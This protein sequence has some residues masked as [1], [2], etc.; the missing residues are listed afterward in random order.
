VAATA[1]TWFS[2]RR[3][4]WFIYA[5]VLAVGL[6]IA[7]SGQPFWQQVALSVGIVALVALSWDILARCG[8]VSLGQS[9]FMGIGAYAAGILAPRIGAPAGMILAVLISAAAAAGLGAITLRLRGMYFSIATMGFTLSLQVA[10][11]IFPDLTGGAGGISPPTLAGG[12][13]AGQM[14]WVT[15]ALL[16]AAVVS[17]YFLN[18]RFRPALLMI[19]SNDA[20]AAASGIP[21]VATKVL[22]FTVSGGL[23]GLGG[24]LFG[25]LYGYLTPTDIFTSHLSVQILAVSI[26]GGSDTT[27]GPILGAV[28]LRVLEE[29]SRAYISGIGYQVV[30]G[31]VII[32]VIALV[33]GG[34]LGLFGRLWRRGR[35]QSHAA[36]S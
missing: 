29:L 28:V 14:V 27:A 3:G 15:L 17:D 8:L 26:L 7:G 10:V 9:A 23:A 4:R 19:R 5:L 11:L 21:V 33:P 22:A 24:I 35:G 18:H 32:A 36:R 16:A 31:A 2:P 13:S 6:A 30:Y 20:L 1:L 34:L 25:G 12:R